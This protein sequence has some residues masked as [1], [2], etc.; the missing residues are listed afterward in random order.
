M[1]G[2]RWD[3]MSSM[4][5]CGNRKE[6]PLHLQMKILVG[7]AWKETPSCCQYRPTDP[8]GEAFIPA[9]LS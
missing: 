6:T 2:Q 7:P 4:R 8:R 9:G 5:G 1:W 3:T